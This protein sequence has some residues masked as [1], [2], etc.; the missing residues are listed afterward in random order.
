MFARLSTVGL[1]GIVSLSAM[2]VSHAFVALNLTPATPMIESSFIS[3]DY[4]GNNSGG[5]LTASGFA[6]VLTPPGSP[7]GNIVNGTFDINSNINSDAQ[8]A[9]GT[10]SIGGT[11]AS[12]GFNSGSILTGTF[13][14][15]AGDPTFGAG[16][17][18]PLEFLFDI[19]GGDAAGLYGG[20]GAT[21]GVI[22]SQSGYVGSFASNFS[23]GPFQALS[24]TFVPEPPPL[25]LLGDV[26]L[27]GIVNGLDVDPFVALVTGGTYQPEADMN[28]DAVV[29]GLDVDPFVAAV[30]G[31]AAQT[32][33]E[34]TTLL[35]TLI[36]VACPAARFVAGA[37]V[38]PVLGCRVVEG[39][40][41]APGTE[42]VLE[43]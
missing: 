41:A 36:G 38:L 20:I 34:P 16:A 30:L 10:L 17:G 33:P 26:D 22:L 15:T 11:I 18:D 25:T 29:N 9:R 27:D 13:S 35:L 32:V 3:V 19:T 6:S 2:G 21:S 8:T 37:I 28:L 39:E 40:H 14:S 24:N 5:V 23:S 7:V 1:A 42:P 43:G 12:Q 31:S 4:I